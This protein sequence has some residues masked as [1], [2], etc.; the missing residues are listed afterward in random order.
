MRREKVAVVAMGCLLALA[1]MVALALSP[2]F[3]EQNFQAFENPKD[4]SNALIYIFL[5]LILTAI[6]LMI[7]KIRREKLVRYLILGAMFF[8]MMFV[9]YPPLWY[10]LSNF[11]PNL[12]EVLTLIFSNLLAF[13]LTY[14]LHKYPEWYL[15]DATGLSVAAGVTAILG[16]SLAIL[17][18]LILLIGLAVYDAIS[19]YKT[20]HMITLADAV[21]GQRLPIL[22]IIPK[23]LSYSFLRQRGL[24][25]QLKAGEEREAMFMGL[26]DIIVPGVLVVSALTSLPNQLFYGILA[27]LLVSIFTLVGTIVGFA[28]LMRFVLRGNPQAGL[29]LLNSG[30][31][32]GYFLSYYFVYQDLTFGMSLRW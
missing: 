13:L 7:I 22:L 11:E 23:S 31:I 4:P 21:T 8:T 19:V 17:P 14:G 32:L 16:I 5:L 18:S 3:K 24:K 10:S 25:E 27:N 9:F 20:K 29:P 6:I 15:V 1:Q 2:L 12:R 30:A 28:I 26:G